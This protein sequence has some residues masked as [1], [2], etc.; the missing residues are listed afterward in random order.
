MKIQSYEFIFNKFFNRYPQ[1]A[2]PFLCCIDGK[3]NLV[4]L[5]QLFTVDPCN[6]SYAGIDVP[7]EVQVRKVEKKNAII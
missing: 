3:Q 1:Y 4:L 6:T 7:T 5:E 2:D